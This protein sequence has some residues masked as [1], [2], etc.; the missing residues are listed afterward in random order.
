MLDRYDLTASYDW[1]YD[2][3]PDPLVVEIPDLP[4]AFTYAGLPAKSPFAVAAGPLLNGRWLLYYASLG[5]DVLTYKTV[6]SRA[7][8]CYPL[9]NLVP[10][11]DQ[12]QD[13]HQCE[14]ETMSE[15]WAVSFGMPSRS[16]E[17][18]RRDIE[19]TR[20]Q[21]SADKILAVSVVGTMQPG[22]GIEELAADYAQC[23]RW[24]VEAGADVVE[25]NLSCPNVDTCDGQLFRQPGY[26]AIVAAAVTEAAHG[27]PL[28][29]KIGHLDD[30]ELATELLTAVAA[31]TVALAMTNSV[32]RP[33]QNRD[34]VP[35][36]GGQPRGI[37]G[38]AILR[39]SLVQ[40]AMFAELIDRLGL[41]LRLIGVG[42][43]STSAHI[44]QY[45][46]RGCESV[47]LGT[48]PMLE[49]EIAIALRSEIRT[50]TDGFA[51]TAV[52]S[53]H[54]AAG[55]RTEK[56]AFRPNKRGEQ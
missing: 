52:K 56:L 48:A 5:F 24:A 17:Q 15:T 28:I 36:F 31:H 20:D 2:H 23:A 49:P 16:P 25:A 41:N 6:R 38:T 10:V 18:W 21:L 3:P 53:D 51:N 50:A 11:P 44:E 39:E 34:G 47:Q 7:H 12:L 54:P 29:L 30:P 46:Q 26:A 22:W 1:N 55:Q 37:C 19:R 27:A 42:G 32:A 4:G 43:A 33:V 45:R 40:V 14:I 35:L 9:P 13:S 8:A